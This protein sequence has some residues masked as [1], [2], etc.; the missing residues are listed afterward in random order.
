LGALSPHWRRDAS[1]PARIDSL[2][3]ADRR[4]GSRDRRLYRELAYTALR[5]LPWVK[6]LLGTDPA[7]AA[8]RL[9][10]LAADTPEVLPFRAEVA[11]GMP[12]CPAGAGSKA[13]IL[14]E[15]ADALSPAWLRAECPAALEPPLR[16]ALLSRAPLWIRLQ[17]PRPGAVLRELDA[18]GVPWQRSPR[19]P[20]AIRLPPDAKVDAMDSYREGLFEVQDAGSQ[21]VL[22]AAAVAP[23]GRWLDACAGAGGKS[24]QLAGLLGP[25]GRV[26]ARDARPEPLAELRRRAGRAGLSERIS[27]GDPADPEGGF[28]GVL[29]DAP[30]TGSGTWRR[31][32]HLRWVTT[33]AGIDSAAR[34]Q[35]RLLVENA[36][37]VR[38]GGTLVYATCS[39]CLSENERVVEALLGQETDLAP[40]APPTRLLPWE[41]DGDGFFV[42][43][44]RR[45]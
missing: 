13:E 42:A 20:S 33:P 9:A 34:L 17:G 4:L 7:Q 15:S 30:C 8:R 3:R 19:L 16:E 31:A 35:L 6:P 26:V 1:L 37:R 40:S 22:E 18:R 23:A 32:P 28:D 29:V 10:W 14:G 39:L 36:R 25:G 21:L 27:V 38:R 5:Y 44:F 45:A 11:R 12:P 24:L 43:V 41:H 2:L